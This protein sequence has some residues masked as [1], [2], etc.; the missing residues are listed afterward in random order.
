MPATVSK[1]VF[2]FFFFERD[3]RFSPVFFEFKNSG[4]SF[5]SLDAFFSCCHPFLSFP[6]KEKMSEGLFGVL[7][8]AGIAFAT[9]VL[10]SDVIYS[11]DAARDL[12]LLQRGN[13]PGDETPD[14]FSKEGDETDEETRDEFPKEGD[15]TFETDVDTLDEFPEDSSSQVISASPLEKDLLFG[16]DCV[17]NLDDCVVVAVDSS[18]T[19]A[20]MPANLEPTVLAE[21]PDGEQT[22]KERNTKKF[23]ELSAGLGEGG[24][25]KGIYQ[26]T[27]KEFIP[28]SSHA[29]P[30]KNQDIR[31]GDVVEVLLMYGGKAVYDSSA[32]NPNIGFRRGF[33]A[34]VKDG[35]VEFP[36]LAFATK[37]PI[38]QFAT[39]D[40]GKLFREGKRGFDSKKIP[41]DPNMDFPFWTKL[42]TKETRIEIEM[43]EQCR[44]QLMTTLDHV[45]NDEYMKWRER[46]TRAK[47][48]SK[49]ARRA[50][51]TKAEETD[52]KPSNKSAKKRAKS[53]LRQA[54]KERPKKRARSSRKQEVTP[55]EDMLFDPTRD[56]LV[57]YRD[58][59]PHD[60]ETIYCSATP[61]D[62]F[63]VGYLK[64]NAPAFRF[65]TSEG[66][67]SYSIEAQP[68]QTKI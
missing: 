52:D 8:P 15:K 7:D 32:R 33:E 67:D 38:M 49:G 65:T 3:F 27:D 45:D 23:S 54:T 58:A 59:T 55:K 28:K 19:R 11:K 36:V 51:R 24:S 60:W 30:V 10:G 56:N 12:R 13:E 37:K 41:N 50:K 4:H 1:S 53:S 43:P 9:G 64:L 42:R 16:D 61:S 29:V 47:N 66:Y 22:E 26:V 40:N 21:A 57:A 6:K 44:F 25:S 17:H 34:K 35:W 39:G 68:D 5:T 14:E 2:G 46:E 63:L 48:T 31:D 18:S 20:S 62:Q